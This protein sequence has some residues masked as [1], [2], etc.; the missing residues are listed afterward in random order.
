MR[1]FVQLVW[2]HMPGTH[3]ARCWCSF[4][5]DQQ[6]LWNGDDAR[7]NK[8]S[9]VN[10]VYAVSFEMGGGGWLVMLYWAWCLDIPNGVLY[11]GRSCLWH[12]T[13][14]RKS[15]YN[16]MVFIDKMNKICNHASR[17]F[18]FESQYPI[19]QNAHFIYQKSR[20]C[21]SWLFS[22]L[23]CSFHLISHPNK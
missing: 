3:S 15:F 22:I 21:I 16:F 5:L 4:H 10:V 18:K 7:M 1:C 2:W 23:L 11:N 12:V 19:L 9:F 13:L 6:Q 20:Q 14:W 17:L 8:S